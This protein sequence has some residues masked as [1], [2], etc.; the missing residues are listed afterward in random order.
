VTDEEIRR[1]LED[2]GYPRHVVEGGREYLVRRYREFVDEVERGYQYGLHEYRHD[3]DLRGALRLLGL[4]EEV[5]DADE[6]L[7]A[8]LT[9]AAGRV[10][11]STPG[12]PFWDFG[13][14]RNARGRLLAQ[15]RS[16]GL[17]AED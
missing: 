17:I 6:R 11:E 3:L 10:W 1:F 14:P 2:N 7:E 15:L 4:D 5:R 9:R 12:D 16:A 13:Y 8:A